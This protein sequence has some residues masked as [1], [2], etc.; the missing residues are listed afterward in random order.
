MAETATRVRSH[1]TQSAQ[2]GSNGVCPVDDL[3]AAAPELR[4]PFTASAVRWKVQ[5]TW[6]KADPAKALIVGYI[7]ARL[8]IERLNLVIPH[9]WAD[10]Y[11]L[12]GGKLMWCHLTVGD[13]TRSD[14]GEGVGKGL[15]SDALKR[16][17]VHFG[18][19]VSLYALPKI[20]LSKANGHLSSDTT[21]RGE[22]ALKLTDKGEEYCRRL[23]QDWL[24]QTGRQAFGEPLDHGDVEDAIGDHDAE[25]SEQ[26]QPRQAAQRQP[27][28]K[29]AEDPEEAIAA[30]IAVDGDGGNLGEKRAEANKGMEL[31]GAKP[32]QRLRELRA[33]LGG[34]SLDEL[35]TRV[36]AAADAEGAS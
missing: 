6:P 27:E 25:R 36:H 9:L 34:H 3:R 18:V 29:P 22:K 32:E 16:A 13:V 28:Q 35:I 20:V 15:V 4:R 11:D 24:E 5:A 23:Y 7:D 17:A 14:V 30:L 10:S 1:A 21:S 12:I 26:E 33:A 19:G 2:N 31:L 8:A